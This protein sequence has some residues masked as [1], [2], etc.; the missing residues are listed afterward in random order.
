VLVVDDLP[1]NRRLLE[2]VLAQYGA[3][4]IPA[5]SAADA[6]AAVEREKLDLAVLDYLMPGDNGIALARQLRAHPQAAQMPLI[7]VASAQPEAD[8]KPL[9][10]FEA[11][12]LKPIRSQSFAAAAARALLQHQFGAAPA[13]P[14]PPAVG[15]AFAQA[16]P[17]HIAVVDDNPVNLKVIAATLRSFGYT[18]ALFNDAATALARLGE[19]KFDLVLMD[20]QMPELDGHEATRRLRAGA[21]GELNRA[22]HVVALTA[23]AMAEERAACLAAGMDDFMPKPVSRTE[24]M[25]KLAAAARKSSRSL[26][27]NAGPTL[28]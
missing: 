20:V 26:A 19:E 25:E 2:R 28:S 17:L 22:L 11:V 8:E 13:S 14:L 12:L 24:L 1:A 7:L 16:H 3:H 9:E 21:A 6:L 5:H 27:A 10:L 18:P 23:G 15:A 4:M